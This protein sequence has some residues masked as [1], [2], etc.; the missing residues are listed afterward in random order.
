M[1][2][3]HR[4]QH[5]DA[6]LTEGFRDTEGTYGADHVF[7]GVFV[8][9]QPLDANSGAEG[10]YVLMIDAPEEV[11]TEFEWVEDGKGYREFCVPAAV[12]NEYP[13]QLETEESE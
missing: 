4:T 10:D 2:L 13:V 11:L 3:Y 6:I 5:A 1:R 12:L 9:D 8:A 7:Q